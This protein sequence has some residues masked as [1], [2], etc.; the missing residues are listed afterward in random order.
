MRKIVVLMVSLVAV[1]FAAKAQKISTKV[2]D[3]KG[4]IKWVI[5]SATQVITK[6]DST[7]LYVTPAQL[8][9]ANGN[10]VKYSD[11]AAMLAP[12]LRDAANGLTKNGQT[13]ELGGD[14]TKPTV[15]NTT[16]ANFLAI[17]GL[18]AGTPGVDSVMVVEAGTGQVKAVAAADLI[19]ALNF[20]NGITRVGTDVKLGGVL[21]EATSIKTDA[22]NTLAIEGL[23]SGDVNTDSVV[24]ATDLGVLKRV[25]ASSFAVKSGNQDYTATAGQSTFNVANLPAVASKVWVYRNGIKLVATTDYTAAAGVVTLTSAMAALIEANDVIEIQWVK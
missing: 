13:V 23:Q 22:T 3:N 5:D 6:A 15:I 20:T 18:Q 10:N 17:T 25:S 19:N 21:S 9:N 14:L 24:L 4:T 12:Y 2:V 8:A 1:G 11:T 16:A 7:I